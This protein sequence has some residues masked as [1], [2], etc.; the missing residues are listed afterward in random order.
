M[1]DQAFIDIDYEHMDDL[2]LSDHFEWRY[3]QIEKIEN[4]STDEFFEWKAVQSK[5]GLTREG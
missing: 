1:N 4:N 2:P 5:K 3:F